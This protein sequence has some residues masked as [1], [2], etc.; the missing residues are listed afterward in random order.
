[1]MRIMETA[2]ELVG[3]ILAGAVPALPYDHPVWT[4][5]DRR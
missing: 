1:M 5:R 3:T 2:L 4:R